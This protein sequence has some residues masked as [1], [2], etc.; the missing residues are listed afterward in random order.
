ML[1]LRFFDTNLLA[2][3]VISGAHS[4]KKKTPATNGKARLLCVLMLLTHQ[5]KINTLSTE[6]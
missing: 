5:S 2:T 6:V 1:F 3:C 4:Q